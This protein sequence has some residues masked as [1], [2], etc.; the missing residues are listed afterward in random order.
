MSLDK[1]NVAP[2]ALDMMKASHE[3]ILQ[4]TNASKEE[5]AEAAWYLAQLT[6]RDQPRKRQELLLEAA[7][8]GSQHG[9]VNYLFSCFRDSVT[10]AVDKQTHREWLVASLTGE[11]VFK[12]LET[13]PVPPLQKRMSRGFQGF[14]TKFDIESNAAVLEDI[15]AETKHW[16]AILHEAFVR[17]VL[18]GTYPPHD[19]VLTDSKRWATIVTAKERTFEKFYIGLG[20]SEEALG[21]D[22]LHQTAVYGTGDVVRDLV[23]T[24]NID[25]EI[26]AHTSFHPGQATALQAALLRRNMGTVQALVDL[27]ADVLPL[28][29]AQTLEA[30][31]MEG[32]RDLLH[33][34]NHLIPLMKRKDN[35]KKARASFDSVLLSGGAVQRTVVQSNWSL[36][37]GILELRPPLV[38]EELKPALELAA[39]LR[40]TEFVLALL[41]LDSEHDNISQETLIHTLCQACRPRQA[42]IARDTIFP[43]HYLGL[44]PD[45]IQSIKTPQDIAYGRLIAEMVLHSGLIRFKSKVHARS[46]MEEPLIQAVRFNRMPLARWFISNW[47][48][49]PVRP[50]KD[51]ET[52]LSLAVFNNSFHAVKY[53]LGLPGASKMIENRSF[54]GEGP[55]HLAA[56]GGNQQII[57]ML[58]DA[59]AS[60]TCPGFQGR[61]VL[62]LC[63]SLV[64]KRAFC[65]LFDHIEQSSPS[66]LRAM[67][68]HKDSNG[69]TPFH[70]FLQGSD[71]EPGTVSKPTSSQD[72]NMERILSAKVLKYVDDMNAPDEWDLTPLHYLV[73][74]NDDMLD[75]I[76]L[77]FRR[78]ADLLRQSSH[79]GANPLQLLTRRNIGELGIALLV[80]GE[81]DPVMRD[82]F[83][84]RATEEDGTDF[85][86]VNRV[87]RSRVQILKERT[88]RET[89]QC[90]TEFSSRIESRGRLLG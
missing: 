36:F 45:F 19:Q 52:I 79:I 61:T 57:K 30:F 13:Y 70:L 51:G 2:E 86:K 68:N 6:G 21:P 89:E 88:V 5:R 50:D 59:G 14:Y 65:T 63:A 39:C 37:M 31:L 84:K 8:L 71:P 53:I 34:L 22:A 26:R 41:V 18:G 27:G 56:A 1:G 25:I 72:R 20:Y 74:F 82:E 33:W 66:T 44:Q 11:F 54:L 78:G 47:G 69:A 76:T 38:D 10:V 81:L 3:A 87:L 80:S 24:H 17:D 43:R 62:H 29:S 7:K 28:F 32:D 40:R 15:G 64:N 23:Q 49:D 60:T 58:L 42:N 83:M 55:I 67:I 16:V 73:L 48:V 90:R 75:T 85:D 9:Q 35:A 77:L 4:S 12:K 46:F